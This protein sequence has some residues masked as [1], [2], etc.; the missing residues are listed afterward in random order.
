MS[1]Y[2]DWSSGG[3]SGET[4]EAAGETNDTTTPV[5]TQR[6]RLLGEDELMCGRYAKAQESEPEGVENSDSRADTKFP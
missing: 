5:E 2:A 4:N 6:R 3:A 1:L